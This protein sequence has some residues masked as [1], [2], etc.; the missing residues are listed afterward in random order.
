MLVTSS[1]GTSE[2]ISI[3]T[4][5]RDIILSQILEKSRIGDDTRSKSQLSTWGRRVLWFWYFEYRNTQMEDSIRMETLHSDVMQI[6][7]LLVI[8]LIMHNQL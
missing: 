5:S 1:V 3:C 4:F 7:I 2:I 8:Q 6:S